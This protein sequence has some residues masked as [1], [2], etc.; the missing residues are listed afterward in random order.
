MRVGGN[1]LITRMRRSGVARSPLPDTDVVGEAFARQVE[2]RLRP[3]IKCAP[4]A[5]V[6]ECRVVRLGEAMAEIGTPAMIG[7]VGLEEA[8]SQALVAMDA[9]LAWHLTDLVM[10]GDP[11]DPGA[12]VVRS[13]TAVDMALC[14]P[15]LAALVAA[16]GAALAGVL[17]RPVPQAFSLTG[18]RQGTAQ[19]R[20]APDYVDALKVR[21]DLTIGDGDRRGRLDLVVPLSMLDV[22]RAA[23]VRQGAADARERP[24]DLWRTAMRR[25]A[26]TAPVTLRA[27]IHREKMTLGAI[28]RL[29]VGTVIEIDPDAP[30]AVEIAIAQTGTREATL[31][32]AQL[33]AYRGR[34]VVRLSEDP[35]P[36]LR[37]H[38]RRALARHEPAVPAP[39]PPQLEGPDSAQPRTE[40]TPSAGEV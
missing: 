26:A 27:V 3:F 16:F 19:V 11:A 36:R 31:A 35:D 8:D 23:I 39:E 1:V 18:Q 15:L 37:E 30:R 4:D 12:P 29:A 5:F 2:D 6:H 17:G 25:A 28:G 20:I 22:I 24:N 13:F 33:G 38:L 7:I 9:V 21:L 32:R 40:A 34:K 14:R 10:G